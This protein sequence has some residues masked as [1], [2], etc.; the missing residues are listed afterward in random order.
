WDKMLELALDGEKPRRYRQSSLPI[1]KE[2]CTMCGDLCA[3]KRS[4]EILE[5]TL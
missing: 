1:D 2:V 4:R 5:N 3:V